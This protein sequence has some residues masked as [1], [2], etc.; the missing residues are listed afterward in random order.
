MARKKKSPRGT[1]RGSS[2]RKLA[3]EVLEEFREA[4]KMDFEGQLLEHKL[5][6]HTGRG[7]EI[8]AGDIDAAWD[9]AD[10]GEE[11]VGGTVPTPDQDVVDEVGEAAGLT[12]ED[13]EPLDLER[14]IEKRDRKR[15]ELNPASS[16]DYEE[17]IKEMRRKD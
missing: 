1:S 8:S 14:K 3:R 6:A 2:N 4:Q 7:P 5:L 17:R 15:W 9:Q 10:A 16:E 12:Y 11:T 13:N